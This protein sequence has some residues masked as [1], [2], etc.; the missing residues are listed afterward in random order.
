MDFI[1]S[2][3]FIVVQILFIPLAIVGFILI[4]YNTTH[5]PWRYS[6]DIMHGPSH[7]GLPPKKESSYNVRLGL[8]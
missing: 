4:A 7:I 5:F 2:L 6:S 1:A 8:G 3:V